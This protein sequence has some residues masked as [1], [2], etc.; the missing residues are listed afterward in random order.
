MLLHFKYNKL[1]RINL[2][3]PATIPPLSVN[4]IPDFTQIH[5]VA[6]GAFKSDFCIVQTERVHNLQNLSRFESIS[7]LNQGK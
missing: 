2:N 4:P 1:R 3:C 6:P 5:R 7:A